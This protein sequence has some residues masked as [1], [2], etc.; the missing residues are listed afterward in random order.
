MTDNRDILAALGLDKNALIGPSVAAPSYPNPNP[1][2]TSSRKAS[3]SSKNRD[4]AAYQLEDDAED[5]DEDDDVEKPRAEVAKTKTVS[6]PSLGTRSSVRN[7]GKEVIDYSGDNFKN[8]HSLPTVVSRK[9]K[10]RAAGGDADIVFDN[11]EDGELPRHKLGKRTQNPKTFGHI[12]GVVVGTMWELRMHCSTAGV[13]APPVSGI[14]GSQQTGAWSIALSGGYEDDIDLGYG[15]TFTGAGGR[16]L[17]GTKEKPKNL[18]TAPQSCDQ[19]W[20]NPLNAALKKSSE[21]HKPVRV[22]RG[23]KLQSKYAPVEGYRYDGLYTVEKA[24]M[25]RGINKRGYKVCKFAF[26]ASPSLR[27]AGQPPLPERDLDAE[28]RGDSTDAETDDVVLKWTLYVVVVLFCGINPGIKSAKTGHHFAHP[29]NQF[30][31]ALHQSGLTKELLLPSED[32]TMPDRYNYGLTNIVVRPSI[33]STE[34]TKAEKVAS[35]PT[36]L[37]K[38][39]QLRPRIVCFIGREVA[40]AVETAIRQHTRKH[41]VS[42]P[43]KKPVPTPDA[44]IKTESSNAHSSATAEDWITTSAPDLSQDSIVVTAEAGFTSPLATT[45][46]GFRMMSY[47]IVHDSANAE[48][49]GSIV[50]ETLFFTAPSTSGLV[51]AYRLEDRVQLFRLLLIEKRAVANG[52]RTTTGFKPIPPTLYTL[53]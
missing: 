44:S 33:S 4:T 17:R 29:T 24:W 46:P 1:L 34:L 25:E 6:R 22:I 13:H 31:R 2:K 9:R 28:R 45:A 32:W 35:V 53:E 39:S 7:A 16:D 8:A 51:T 20:N 14:A 3:V 47:K 11:L 19:S 42:S 43:R 48:G 10:S 52:T 5:T 49:N 36:F 15:F 37:G 23:Y 50:T 27:V 18:R 41:G 12:P 40:D 38:V 30:Y 21:T 26:K